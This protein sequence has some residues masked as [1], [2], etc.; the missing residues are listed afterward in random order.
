MLRSFK[1]V[2]AKTLVYAGLGIF[3]IGIIVFSIFIWNL[4]NSKPKPQTVSNQPIT[5]RQLSTDEIRDTL[6]NSSNVD[7]VSTG[8]K[9]TPAEAR[10]YVKT[11]VSNQ[12]KA[13]YSQSQIVENTANLVKQNQDNGSYNAQFSQGFITPEVGGKLVA[14]NITVTFPSGAVDEPVLVSYQDISNPGNK[15]AKELQNQDSE[16]GS[17]YKLTAQTLDFKEVTKFNKDITIETKLSKDTYNSNLKSYFFNQDSKKWEYVNTVLKEGV[18]TTTTNHFTTFVTAS[19][20][21]VT[22]LSCNPT[23]DPVCTPDEAYK[24]CGNLIDDSDPGTSTPDFDKSVCFKQYGVWTPQLIG[25]NNTSIFNQAF[26]GVAFWNPDYTKLKGNVEIFVTVPPVP[27]LGLQS[28]QQSTTKYSIFHSGKIDQIS[29]DQL[30]YA[31]QVVSL[32]TFDFDTSTAWVEADSIVDFSTGNGFT[33]VDAACFAS[34]SLPNLDLIPPKIENV[35]VS[36]VNGQAFVEAKVTDESKGVKSVYFSLNGDLTAMTGSGDIYSAVTNYPYG[37]NLDYYILAYDNSGNESIWSPTFGYVTRGPGKKI[38]VPTEAW[39]INYKRAKN[40]FQ[41]AASAKQDPCSGCIGDPVNTQNGS[42][43]EQVELLKIPGRPEID[44]SLQYNSLGGAPS[45]FGESWTH[46]YNYHLVEMDN[47]SFK[48]VFVTDSTGYTATFNGSNLTPEAGNND[49]LSRNGSGFLLTKKDKTRLFFDEF[50]DLKRQEDLQ[51]NGLNFEYVNQNEFVNLSKLVKITADGGRQVFL[52]YNGQGLVDSIAAPEGKTLNFGYSG[53]KDLISVVDARGGQTRFEYD[54]S[55]HILKKISPQGEAFYQNTYDNQGRVTSQLAGISFLQKYSYGVNST[56]VTDTYGNTQLY[57]YD[58]SGLMLSNTDQSG[59]TTKFEYND[60]KQVVKEIDGAD[61][62]YQYVYDAGN[63]QVQVI[64]PLG[65]QISRNF[66]LNLN[67]PLGEINKIADHK[68]Q[69]EY[70]SK[71]NLTKI[72]DSLGGT[73]IR[74]YNSLSQLIE[75]IDVNSNST[76]YDYNSFGDRIKE[77]DSLG[78]S[79]IYSYDGLGRQIGKTDKRGIGYQYQYDQ[80]NNLVKISGPLG[81][82][83]GFEYDAN[84]RQI[85]QIDANGG[86]SVI[87][88]NDSELITKITNQLGFASSLEYGLMNEPLKQADPEGRVTTFSNNKSFYIHSQTLTPPNFT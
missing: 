70:D 43:M 1:K 27:S 66:D 3:S 84:N 52:N 77:T 42:L 40:G 4:N 58:P 33:V 67:K 18:V 68:T 54:N 51:G 11:V 8:D 60:K 13:K 87:E 64:D 32:G 37:Q 22:T 17:N 34:C 86:V 30:A 56:T 65:Q 20:A 2:S 35:K 81:Y 61:N 10:A 49:V 7:V 63:N 29:V 41:P 5:S 72:K 14:G 74:N 57:S 73:E 88:F 80:N 69:W 15:S 82:Q 47:A 53:S 19:S 36:P 39:Y 46:Q 50:G 16:P 31:G 21:P 44:L 78:Q 75:V 12:A 55:H 9:V 38:G 62:I 23:I 26:L 24:N 85:K 6:K 79:I 59:I 76:K 71:G 45:I 28:N 48:G 83:V 25:Y